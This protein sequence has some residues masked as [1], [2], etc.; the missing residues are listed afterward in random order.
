MAIEFLRRRLII[1]LQGDIGLNEESEATEG[2]A[3][4]SRR[5]TSETMSNK[6]N[7]TFEKKQ[8]RIGLKQR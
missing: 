5:T 4:R 6:I 3:E 8:K 7:P 1:I 2:G